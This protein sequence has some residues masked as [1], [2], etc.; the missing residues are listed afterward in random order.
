MKISGLS[1]KLVG[2][3]IALIITLTFAGTNAAYS[4]KLPKMVRTYNAADYPEYEEYFSE[5]QKQLDK[6]FT[7]EKYFSK[8]ADFYMTYRYTIS[9]TGEITDML[10]YFRSYNWQRADEFYYPGQY[11][12][13]WYFKALA[14]EMPKFEEYVKE[15]ILNNPPKPFPK[16]FEYD[17]FRMEVCFNYMPKLARFHISRAFVPAEIQ[18]S[19]FDGDESTGGDG[20]YIPPEWK[21][22]IYRGKEK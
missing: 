22:D 8:K 2:I 7:P 1:R 21:L 9:S 5:Y 15:I 18:V 4:K 13:P 6:A 14:K 10:P 11:L 16:E 20:R 17:S 19:K 12:H 3:S